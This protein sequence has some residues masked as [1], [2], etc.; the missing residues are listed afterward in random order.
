[1]ICLVYSK[2]K[3]SRRAIT[4]KLS[5]L[6]PK[7]K[8]MKNHK[9]TISTLITSGL[10]I[11]STITFLNMGGGGEPASPI[12]L[13][14]T[15]LEDEGQSYIAK[16]IDGDSVTRVKD[17]SFTG[18]TSIGGI[19]RKTDDG[20]TSSKIEID[21]ADIKELEVVQRSFSVKHLDEREFTVVNCISLK[22]KSIK[23][24]L[25]PKNVI[26]SAKSLEKGMSNFKLTWRLRDIDKIVIEGLKII[27]ESGETARNH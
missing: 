17:I 2:L 23:N 7:D 4:N 19:R 11:F 22:N 20:V 3:A 12:E 26:I 10:I 21:L 27:V 25:F 13:Q 6:I 18:R 5:F 1:M 15:E 9:K 8:V 16:I 24:L 14:F